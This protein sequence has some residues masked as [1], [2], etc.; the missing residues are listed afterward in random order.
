M[1]VILEAV[2]NRKIKDIISDLWAS[3]IYYGCQSA[4]HRK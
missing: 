1:N 4:L 2:G 3:E